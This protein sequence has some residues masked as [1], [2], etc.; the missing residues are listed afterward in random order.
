MVDAIRQGKFHVYAIKTIDEGLE[1]LTDQPA[2]QRQTNGVYPEATV[3]FLVEKRLKEL[4][5]S[6]RGYYEGL[7]A[8]AR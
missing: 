1:V 4:H 5:D 6:M 2:G 3:N 7:L 8:P